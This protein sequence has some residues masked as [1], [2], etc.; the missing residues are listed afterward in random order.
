MK[1][2]IVVVGAGF[3]GQAIARRI[4]ASKHLLLANLTEQA[5]N[6]AADVLANA[7]FEV[8]AAPVDIS[9]RNSVEALL[10]KAV[11]LGD[12][13]RPVTVTR[14]PA[15]GRQPRKRPRPIAAPETGR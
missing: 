8:S 6:E 4:G 13:T 12:W 7:G 5:S 14:D 3:L 15:V 2:V 9:S 10:V 11:A 1:E